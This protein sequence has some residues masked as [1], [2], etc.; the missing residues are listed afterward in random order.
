MVLSVV[1]EH[2]GTHLPSWGAHFFDFHLQVARWSKRPLTTVNF[3]LGLA[4]HA[5]QAPQGAPQE[6]NEWH[7][8][9]QTPLHPNPPLSRHSQDPAEDLDLEGEDLEGGSEV[10]E[11]GSAG[12]PV[13]PMDPEEEP[14]PEPEPEPCLPA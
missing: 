3:H 7:A 9:K 4:F 12:L 13:D 2:A 10:E 6:A 14:E 1:R 11:T 8:I 5:T